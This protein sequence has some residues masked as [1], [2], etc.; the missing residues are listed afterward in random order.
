MQALTIKMLIDVF[1]E[2]V[3]RSKSEQYVHIHDFVNHP[4]TIIE[5]RKELEKEIGDGNAR[6]ERDHL[7]TDVRVYL[8]RDLLAKE[9]RNAENKSYNEFKN[10]QSPTLSEILNYKN[11]AFG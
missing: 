10:H 11:V 6:T 2:Y 9:V 7:A 3:E 5:F 8:F 4:N 1:L